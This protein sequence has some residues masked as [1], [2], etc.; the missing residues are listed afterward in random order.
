ML[1]KG[2][3]QYVGPDKLSLLGFIEPNFIKPNRES[4]Y[5]YFDKSCWYINKDAV[6]EIGYESITHHIWEEQKKN[7]PAKY[8]GKPLIHFKMKDG[9]CSYD[10]TKDGSSCQFL[11]F[12]IN[13]SNFTWR[14]K[15]E[16]IDELEENENRIHL[17]SKLCAIGYMAMEAKDN[18]VARAVIG[19]DGKQS[20]VGESNGRSGKSLIGEL[21]RNVVPTAYISG[22]RNDI[23]SDQFIW[24]DVQENTKLVFID[25]VLQNFNFEFL[26]PV[27]TGDWTINYK[28]GR[29]ITIPFVKSAK[30]YIPTN[31]AIRGTGSSYT[32]RQWLVAFSD[33]YNDV[34]KPLDDFGCLFF[35]EWDFDQW[36]LTWNLLANCIQLYLTF[37]VVQAPGERL[38]MRKLRQEITEPLISWADEYFSDPAHLNCRLVRKDLYDAFCNYD[39]TQK[40]FISSTVFKK[41]FKLYCEWK[42]YTFN[43]NKYD[44]VTGQPHQFDKDGN[45]VLDDKAGGVEYFTVGCKDI[46]PDDEEAGSIND[47]PGLPFK[48]EINDE[49]IEY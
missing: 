47:Y 40:K 18:N 26:F 42:G 27:I 46:A 17:L 1:I 6:K 33:Y 28:G 11:T 21:M 4:Q 8:L 36:N 9:Q 32:D 7:I 30:I 22:K 14:K 49:I 48:A 34:H 13:A 24:N 20:E 16:E 37:G 5:L 35:S 43:P 19:M 25:D 15:T 41:K 39:Q 3:S 38:E 23:F 31:H 45:P 12:L 10:I 44:P 29:R 2:V